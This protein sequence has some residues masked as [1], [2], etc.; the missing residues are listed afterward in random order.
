[1]VNC[2]AC[3]RLE[4]LDLSELRLDGPIMQAMVDSMPFLTHLTLKECELE[5][6]LTSLTR[7]TGLQSLNLAKH[8]SIVCLS[9]CSVLTVDHHVQID[10]DDRRSLCDRKVVSIEHSQYL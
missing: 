5:S 1:M 6:I 2:G 7:L 10:C 8:A 4:R 9:G 3:A